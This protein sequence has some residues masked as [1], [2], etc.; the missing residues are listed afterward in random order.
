MRLWE[1]MASGEASDVVPA[2]EAGGPMELAYP[3]NAT[4][5]KGTRATVEQPDADAALVDRVLAG[6]AEA[7]RELV[8]AHQHSVFTLCLRMLRNPQDAE[9]C[10]QTTFVRAYSSLGAYRRDARFRTWIYRIATNVCIDALRRMHVRPDLPHAAVRIPESTPDARPAPRQCVTR[11]ELRD[12]L[13]QAL[14]ALPDRYRLPLVLFYLEGLDCREVGGMLGLGV[15]TVKTHLRRGR[16]ML[17][18]I[19]DKDWPELAEWEW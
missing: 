16:L 18:E 11:Q 9:E 2:T 6:E 17:R 5:A 3:L 4:V 13:E 1:R 10:A 14:G 19:I 15:A 12:L 7:Y 8:E